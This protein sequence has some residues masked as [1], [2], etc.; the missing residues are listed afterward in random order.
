MVVETPDRT[1]ERQSGRDRQ[2]TATRRRIRT[3]AL[4]V[5]GR[6]GL[7]GARV[8]D[9]AQSAGVSRGTVYFHYPSMEDI[10]GEVLAEAEER[11]GQAVRQ[12]GD[13]APIARTLQVFCDAFVREWE[14]RPTLFRAVAAMSLRLAAARIQT[15]QVD[16]AHRALSERFR[17]AG[18]RRELKG[19]PRG[20]LLAQVFLVNVLAA[21]LAW[22][23]RPKMRLAP[24]LAEVV[25]IFLFGVL[26]KGRRRASVGLA[27]SR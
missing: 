25:E 21:T 5:I 19:T 16:A 7:A 2:R 24:A 13:Q 23:E 8:G 12:V 11:I 1:G 4:E 18:E 9:I 22:A 27:A 14:S 3:V 20:S 17:T 26:P 6:D 10:A 15:K